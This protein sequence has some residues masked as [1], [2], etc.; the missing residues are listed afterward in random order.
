MADTGPG[1][2]PHTVVENH[3]GCPSHLPHGLTDAGGHLLAC[4]ATKKEAQDIALQLDV[5]DASPAPSVPGALPDSP[6][7]TAAA[8]GAATGHWDDV[9]LIAAGEWELST[10]PASFTTADLQSAVAA[11]QCPSVGWPVLKLGHHDP[12]FDGEPAIGSVVGLRLNETQTKIIGDYAGMPDW[13]GDILPSAYPK[14]SVEGSWNFP[15]QQGHIHPFVITAVALLGVTPPGVGTIAG[16]NDIAALYGI[17]LPAAAPEPA[18]AA[19]RFTLDLPPGGLMPSPPGSTPVFRAAG[20]ATTIDDVRRAFYEDAPWS[21]WIIELQLDPPVLIV[22]DD[23]DGTLYRVPVELDAKAPGTV[24]FGPQTAVLVQYID[25]PP[26]QLEQAKGGAGRRVAAAWASA[27]VSAAG[28]RAAST[29]AWDGQ[30]AQTNL[31]EDP[32]TSAIKALYALPADTKTASKLPH[33]EVSSDGKVGEANLAACSAA[34]AA[35]NGGRGGLKGVSADDKQSAYNHLAKHITDAGNEAPEYS[36]GAPGGAAAAARLDRLLA[37]RA[38]VGDTDADDDLHMLIASLDALL[39]QASDLGAAVDR[40]AVPEAAG[41]ALDMITAAEAIV[42]Q[43][44]D[45]LGIYDPDDPASD[46]AAAVAARAF[47]G[48]QTHGP[49]DGEHSHPHSAF[50]S[51]GGDMTHVHAHAHTNDGVHNHVHDPMS[52]APTAASQEGAEVDFTTDQMAAIRSR[53]GKK[54]GDEVT[55]AELAAALTAP[56]APT[57]DPAAAAAPDAGDGDGGLPQISEGTYLVDSAILRDYQQ[58]AL[59]GDAAAHQLRVNER[60]QV[61]AE[62]MRVGKFPQARLDHYRQLWDKDPEGTRQHVDALAAGLVPVG[63]GAKGQPGYDPDMPGDFEQ[64]AAYATLYPED[65]H[66]GVSHAPGVRGG[67]RRA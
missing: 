4:H 10:G 21:Q 43:L 47:E 62:A 52:A 14:R 41:Q 42:D 36:G 24:K 15:C 18:E 53:L 54:D 25:A 34:I 49:F 61:L 48:A 16:L 40:K 64:Q 67:G 2:G 13:L 50:G 8:T 55:A 23:A 6:A 17:D 44:M 1:A 37:V 51:Q 63:T 66:G 46:V 39:D 7:V 35:L 11:A 65:A 28:V 19:A 26:G 32:P 56:P 9:E 22:S 38:A 31:G 60:D 30:Q 20:T 3:P 59:A 45:M 5:G 27:A 57:F 29:G 58:R 12:R 33:H